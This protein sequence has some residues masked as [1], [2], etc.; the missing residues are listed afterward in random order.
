ME[1][2]EANLNKWNIMDMEYWPSRMVTKSTENGKMVYS[3]EK[4]LNTLK[5]FKSCIQAFFSRIS[6][7]DSEK[8][9]ILDSEYP[10]TKV[11]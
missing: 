10:F 9:E 1:N 2:I 8:S 6:W 3:L 5:K 7:M 11:P 4:L